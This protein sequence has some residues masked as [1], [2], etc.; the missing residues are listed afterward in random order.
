MTVDD[1]QYPKKVKIVAR[2]LLF[3]L[4]VAIRL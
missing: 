1:C 4:L 2:L 3:F